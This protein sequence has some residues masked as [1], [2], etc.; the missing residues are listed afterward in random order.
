MVEPAP[1]RAVYRALVGG[2]ET[3]REESVAEKSEVDFVCFTDD[4]DLTSDTWRLVV[5]EPRFPADLVRSARHL[6]IVG[7]PVLDGYDETLWLDNSVALLAAPEA[8]LDDWLAGADVALPLHSYRESVIDEAEA[9]LNAGRDDYVRVYEQLSVYLRTR[10]TAMAR[11]PH[12]TGMLARR[13]TQLVDAAMQEWWEELLRFSHRD[14]LSF[15]VTVPRPGLRLRSV[16]LDNFASALHTWPHV[17]N[18][19]TDRPGPSLRDSLRPPSAELGLVRQQL[20]DAERAHAWALEERDLAVRDLS[21]ELQDAHV[22]RK[23]REGLIASLQTETAVLHGRLQ[24]A[25]TQI[26]LLNTE[27]R[28]LQ[29]RLAVRRATRNGADNAKGAGSV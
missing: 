1:R 19:R 11:N 14:Q 22:E 23:E 25:L 18:R 29:N 13:R 3:L 6:K 16:E 21:A 27:V 4:P 9:V 26:D 10:T 7:H 15:A 8:I 20:E 2:Y 28:R 5:V 12:W 24:A 17:D